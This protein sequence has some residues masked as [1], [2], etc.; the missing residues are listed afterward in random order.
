MPDQPKDDLSRRS[1]LNVLLGAGVF[2]WAGSVCYPIFEYFR[3]PPRKDDEPASVVAAKFAD[4][5][6]NQ[7]VIFKFGSEPGL[8][9]MTPDGKLCA[10]S[11]VCTHLD[12]TVR[13][14]PDLQKIH[15]AC[16]NGM[17]DLNGQ[18]ISGP[19]PRPLRQFKVV[20]RGDDVVVF[21]A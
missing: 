12:C 17:Y 7:G 10:V 2:A 20:Q 4:L 1:F 3:I 16:H 8:L 15:C 18:N 21:R 13:Y 19:P 11:A 9:I 6:P 5:K 14:R